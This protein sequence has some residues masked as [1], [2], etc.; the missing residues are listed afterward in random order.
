M[1]RESAEAQH[2]LIEDLLD[3]SRMLSGELRLNLRPAELAP[4]VQ[5]AIDIVRPMADAK[6]I[7]IDAAVD[8]WAGRVLADPGRVEQIVWN[9]LS[10]AIKFTDPGGAAS[11]RLRRVNDRVQLQVSDTGVGISP[12]FLPHVFERF[13]QAD[14]STTRTE[15]GLGLGLAI[16][17]K[18]VELQGGTIRAESEGEGK[19]ATF[20]VEFPLADVG[21]GLP[22]AGQGAGSAGAGQPFKPLPVLRGARVLVVEDNENARTVVQWTLEQCGA[23]VA[24][25]ASAEDALTAFR[26]SVNGRGYDALVSDIGMSGQDGYALIRDVRALEQEAGTHH[27]VPA[28]ALTAY[29]GEEDRSNALGAGFDAHLPK[30][31]GAA[32]LVRAVAESMG[33]GT[34]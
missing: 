28:V 18:L 32:A 9:L 30:P 14:T 20:T 1:I 33:R 25:V 16:T 12:E 8:D 34:R 4:A 22:T 24:A 21:S 10:N 7:R 3:V 15:G 31:V 17:Q 6:G 5:A 27:H 11:V 26:A 19:G 2:H 13:R 23:E 29:A